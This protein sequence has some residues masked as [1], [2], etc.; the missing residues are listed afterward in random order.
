MT[1]RTIILFGALLA[2]PSTVL[3]Q[4]ASGPTITVH[5]LGTVEMDPDRARVSIGVE[6]EAAGAREAQVETNRVANGILAAIRTLGID[7]DDV[8]TSRVTL[9]PV[10]DDRRAETPSARPTIIAYRAANTVSVDLDDLGRI[11]P[12]IDAA[13]EAGANR[14]EGVEFGLRDPSEARGR[15]LRAAVADARSR[16]EAIAGALGVDLG[17]VI[18]TIELGAGPPPVP[19]MVRAESSMVQESTPVTPGKIPVTASLTIRYRLEPE[20]PTRS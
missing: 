12:V 8:Q 19:Y 16:A 14:I 11:G 3:S 10:Y 18:E 17:P 9:Y 5:G 13:I 2:L 20:G 7:P 1:I 4:D 15:A 6:T